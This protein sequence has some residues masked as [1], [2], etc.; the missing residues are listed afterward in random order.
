MSFLIIVYLVGCA[1][2]NEQDLNVDGD[3]S[4]QLDTIDPLTPPTIEIAVA[5]E[6]KRFPVPPPLPDGHELRQVEMMM[7]SATG[8]LYLAASRWLSTRKNNK[9]G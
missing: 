7:R 9:C 8:I 3:P 1:G 4:V 2:Q 6:P 5:N